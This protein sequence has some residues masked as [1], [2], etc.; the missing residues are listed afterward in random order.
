MALTQPSRLERTL[1]RAWRARGP[2]AC[3]LLPLAALFGALSALRRL[4]YRAGWARSVR[5]PVPV[6]VVGNVYVGGTGKTPLTI[7]LVEQLRQAG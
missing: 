5:L 2:L 4:A 7:W 3:A 6:V 1:V